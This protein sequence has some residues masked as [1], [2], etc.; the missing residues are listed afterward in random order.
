[1]VM[2]KATAT[3]MAMA[4]STVWAKATAMAMAMATATASQHC[5]C[6][7]SLHRCHRIVSH[8]CAPPPPR[9]LHLTSSSPLRTPPFSTHCGHHC[10][11]I[12]VYLW[13]GG[14][15][16]LILSSLT[17]PPPPPPPSS[18]SPFTYLACPTIAHH[19]LLDH[20]GWLIVIFKGGRR[21][22]CAFYPNCWVAGQSLGCKLCVHA[23]FFDKRA[24]AAKKAT[25]RD[26]QGMLK[27]IQH[28][29]SVAKL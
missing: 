23:S 13:V 8:S 22:E 26:C 11:L 1:M 10:R 21:G 16:A 6:S 17:L 25:N 15:S 3:A 14:A 27:V 28:A 5:H 7:S 24:P 29:L 2:A 12:F 9:H 19:V 4:M 18:S 20:H